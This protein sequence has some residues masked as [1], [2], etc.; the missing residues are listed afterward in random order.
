MPTSKSNAAGKTLLKRGFKAD[1]ERK[2]VAFRAELG[3]KPHDPLPA[4]LLADHLQIRILTPEQIPGITD[5]ITQVLLGTGK[6]YWSAAIFVK[7]EKKFIIHNPTH[8]QARQESKL[9]HEIAHAVCEH[10]LSELET[11]L[12]NCIIPLRK[13]DPIQEAEAECLGACLQL[14]QPALFYYYHILKKTQPQI[15]ESFLASPDMVK[16]R[17]SISGVTKIKFNNTR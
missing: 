12:E 11:A 16:Y 6:D 4:T 15:S 13:Y 17:L 7:N 9:M 8:S 10:R 14:P 1:A 2:A 5:G 3:L